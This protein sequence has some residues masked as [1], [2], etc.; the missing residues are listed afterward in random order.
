VIPGDTPH[1]D[2]VA[3]EAVEGIGRA[4]AESGV[5]ASFGLLTCNTPGASYRPRRRQ[6][7]Q[8]GI[9]RGYGGYRDGRPDAPSPTWKNSTASAC[10]ASAHR[11]DALGGSQY[12]AAG[13][14]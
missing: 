2:Y 14:I 5:P 4:A 7:R 8:Q 6:E 11:A 9:R 12:S 1:F 13:G 10:R 3:G